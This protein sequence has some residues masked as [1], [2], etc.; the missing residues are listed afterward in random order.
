[1]TTI[2]DNESCFGYCVDCGKKHALGE[3]N[4]RKY[5]R[6]LIAEL[7]Q[8][9]RIDLLCDSGDPRFS[10]D[11]LFGD[12][13]G[14]MFGVLECEDSDGQVVVLKAFSCQYNGAWLVDG[15]CPP[16]LDVDEYNRIVPDVDIEIKSL[17]RQIDGLPS[18]S[19]KR[20]EL[21]R[22]RKKISQDQMKRIHSLYSVHNFKGEV[23]SLSEAFFQGKG[24]PTG[25]GDCCAPKLLNFAAKNNLKPLGLA[26]FYWGKEN[27]SGSKKH[28]EFYSCCEGK[29]KPILGFM[30]CGLV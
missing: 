26:E 30:L 21:K 16:L 10:T 4:A 1:M 6:E 22:R 23:V 15:W 18:D 11:Y 9:Q 3:G 28:G 24:M 8:Q 19:E 17:G 5:C 2:S 27:R 25:T 7:E 20:K 29:C 14:Q 12:A 13:R